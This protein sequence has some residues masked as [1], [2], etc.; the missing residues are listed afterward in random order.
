MPGGTSFRGSTLPQR[1]P[2]ESELHAG[3]GISING[4]KFHPITKR[5]WCLAQLIELNQLPFFTDS[6]HVV[7]SKSPICLCLELVCPAM[8][9]YSASCIITK[10]HLDLSCIAAPRDFMCK[11]VSAEEP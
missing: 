2:A 3:Q 6:W 1:S 4:P 8:S 7:T 5:S 10:K 11:L 9:L